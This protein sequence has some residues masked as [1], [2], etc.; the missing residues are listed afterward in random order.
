MWES[1]L[2]FTDELIIIIP[3]ISCR[4]C[5]ALLQCSFILILETEFPKAL[6]ISRPRK[7]QLS[8]CFFCASR[9]HKEERNEQSYPGPTLMG[10]G[11]SQLLG[12]VSCSGPSHVVLEGTREK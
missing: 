9:H 7:Q 8:G 2:P 3:F 6:S 12:D 5:L 1:M 10:E 11:R 4:D